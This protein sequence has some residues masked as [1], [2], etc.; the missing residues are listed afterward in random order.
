M[1]LHE[2][3]KEHLS[4][5]WP[6]LAGC[7]VLLKSDGAFPLDGPCDLA[8]YGNGARHTL[9]GGTGS[10]EVNTRFFVTAEM[11]LSRAGFRITT[12]DWLDRYDALLSEARAAWVAEMK[13]RAKAAGKL[14]VLYAMGA[15]F[16]TPEYD[17]PL[18]GEGDTAVYVLARGSGEGSDRKYEKGDVLLTDSEVRDILALQEKYKKFM[19]VLNT[20]GPVDLSPVADRVGTILLLSQLGIHT[21]S[22]LARILLGEMNPSGKLSATW[23]ACSEYENAPF[24]EQDDTVYSEGIYVGYRS[25]D[26]RGVRA[27]FP[28]G[29]G[30]SFT[31][32]SV[33]GIRCGKDGNTVHAAAAVTNTGSRSGREVLQLYVSFPEGK[34]D[35]PPKALAGFVKT[36]TLLPGETEN[37]TV[38]ADLARIA[39][40]DEDRAAYVLPAGHYT[41]LLGTSSVH[42]AEAG[43]FVL[44]KEEV[45]RYVRNL[46]GPKDGALPYVPRK[47][48]TDPAIAGLTDE[49]LCSLLVGTYPSRSAALS[50]IG[51]ASKNVPGAAGE[52]KAFEEKGIPAIVMADGPAGLRLTPSYAVSGGKV[53]TEGQS[54][55]ESMLEFLPPVVRTVSGKIGRKTPKDAER[56]EQYCTAL[57][58][59]TAVAQSWDPAFARLCGYIVGREM[60][61]FGVGLFLAP[62]LN[63]QRDVRC[64]RNFEYYSEDPLLSGIIAAAVTAGVQQH[65]GRGACIKHYAA[66]NQETNRFQNSSAVS[67]RAMREIYL[68][69]FEICVK[70]ARPAAVMT[71]YNLLNGIHTSERRDLVTDILRGEWGFDGIVMT[72]WIVHL[73]ADR[74]AKYG[75]PHAAM[76]IA[77]GGD[78][79]MPGSYEDEREILA[80]LR[81]GVLPRRLLE[82]AAERILR[83]AVSGKGSREGE[84]AGND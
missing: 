46:L 35:Q 59:A 83:F 11:G 26:R 47:G 45:V 33:A 8:L 60:E 37:V 14:A 40:Y 69:G 30:L 43:S 19:L 39:S 61:M 55:P 10:G 82:E 5:L 16:P 78:L 3:E 84:E 25:F 27:A 65:P 22:V 21:G 2:Y 49:E 6:H 75:F 58:I 7:T 15:V 81:A 12:Q 62:A 52:T 54:I 77:A 67:E 71:S 9:M 66:N 29:Y 74:K 72:D 20:C 50:F 63:I 64:G 28:F 44:E 24:G 48:E 38:T 57:P 34:L 79:V 4:A 31:S 23:A 70:E 73:A 18:E 42:T 32:F 53:Y 1:K 17:L 51:N 68:R 56:K 41:V 80:A 13:S 76:I 36:R